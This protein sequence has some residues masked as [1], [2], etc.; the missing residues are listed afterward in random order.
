M[1]IQV[2]IFNPKDKLHRKLSI[3]K[4]YTY[5][6]L[7][8]LLPTKEIEPKHYTFILSPNFDQVTCSMFP[9]FHT[10]LQVISQ[11]T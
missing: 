7:F 2:K 5:I 8:R 4:V 3:P 9:S 6:Q 1:K 11:L 10:S